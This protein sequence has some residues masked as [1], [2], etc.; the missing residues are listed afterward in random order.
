MR[1]L[2][3][4]KTI[5]SNLEDLIADFSKLSRTLV[6]SDKM[7]RRRYE[8]YTSLVGQ[9]HMMSKELQEINDLRLS[10]PLMTDTKIPVP[11]TEYPEAEEKLD[12]PR[13]TG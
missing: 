3:V 10:Q 13:K 12:L 2:D 9:L 8:I 5:A 6:V 7:D 11:H 4:N 1:V